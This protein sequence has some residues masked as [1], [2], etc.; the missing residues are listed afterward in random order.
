MK[1]LLSVSLLLA[2]ALLSAQ[3]ERSSEF[4][5]K[6]STVSPALDLL[7]EGSTLR[8]VRIP[9]YDE[10]KRPSALLRA[11]L[12]RV[13]SE[14]NVSG[15]G[16]ELV[17]FSAK[18]AQRLRAHTDRAS[19]LVSKGILE[20]HRELTITGD[21]FRA[22]GSR[23]LFQ[24]DSRRGFL[25][26]PVDTT[27]TLDPGKSL[28]AAMVADPLSTILALAFLLVSAPE[29]L[30]RAELDRNT[31]MTS[32]LAEVY[33]SEV[34][35]TRQMITK[36]DQLARLVDVGMR[37]FVEEVRQPALLRPGGTVTIQAEP[38]KPNPGG[39]HVTCDGGMYFDAEKGHV[40]YLK[41]IHVREPRFTLECEDELKIILKRREKRE[42]ADDPAGGADE[43]ENL[44][45]PDAFGDVQNIIAAGKVRVVRKDPGGKDV[46]ATAE[47][48]TYDA[49]SGDIILQGGFPTVKQGKNFI[50][51]REPG[52]YIR[53]YANGHAYCEPGKWETDVADVEKLREED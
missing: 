24:L 31:A 51:A 1:I 49:E 22:T 40:V 45:G 37:S 48:A 18:G 20:A 23:A 32:S 35:P 15:E 41:N 9:R 3:D 47:T 44:S 33:L 26:G 29:P 16:V 19:Y 42:E 17:I 11:G 4:G 14:E 38:P 52:L 36:S 53:L 5:L 27:F 10:R 43:R 7:P 21:G 6:R 25:H 28:S 8:D 2:P 50:R 46:V 30:T 34:A 12:L 13:V 39:I